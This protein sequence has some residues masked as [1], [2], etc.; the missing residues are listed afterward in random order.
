MGLKQGLETVMRFAA[1]AIAMA[2]VLTTV[3]SVSQ[4]KRTAD[5]QIDPVSKAL[6]QQGVAELSA[7]KLEAATDSLESALVVDPRNREAF[8]ALARIAVKQDLP[9]KAIRYYRE[10]LLIEPNDVGALAGQGEVL[11]K[12]GAVTKAKEN[13]ARIQRLCVSAC[14]EQAQLA[15]AI[16]LAEKAPPVMSAQAVTPNP[17]VTEAPKP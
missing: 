1:P 5:R 8:V 14:A 10:A 7:N 6:T 13:L 17:S 3:S 12:R 2:L 4:G 16:T 11:A 9:G 15:S